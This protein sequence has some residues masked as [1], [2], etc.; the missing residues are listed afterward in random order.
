[1]RSE[2]WFVQ[3]ENDKDLNFTHRLSPTLPFPLNRTCCVCMCVCICT[4]VFGL[5]RAAELSQVTH[6]QEGSEQ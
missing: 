4:S 6:T 3:Y 2:I 5:G 1:M